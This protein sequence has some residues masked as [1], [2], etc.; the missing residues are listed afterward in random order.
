MNTQPLDADTRARFLVLARS[1]DDNGPLA[2][3]TEIKKVTPPEKALIA[4]MLLGFFA[5]PD[6]LAVAPQAISIAPFSDRVKHVFDVL[7]EEARIKPSGFVGQ[8]SQTLMIV[9][10]AVGLVA[11]IAV[12]YAFTR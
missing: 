11:G 7:F 9:G 12:G 5:S 10:A 2:D 8:D 6:A 1:I 4:S 3:K